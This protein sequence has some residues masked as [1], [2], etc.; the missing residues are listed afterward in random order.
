MQSRNRYILIHELF[1]IL[2]RKEVLYM[3]DLE[4]LAKIKSVF[5]TLQDIQIHGNYFQGIPILDELE[6]AYVRLFDRIN[7]DRNTCLS[8]SI[9]GKNYYVSSSLYGDFVDEYGNAY[10]CGDLDFYWYDNLDILLKNELMRD[11]VFG[12]FYALDKNNQ[13]I[14]RTV[15][16]DKEHTKILGIECDEESDNDFSNMK[17]KKIRLS[18]GIEFNVD[19]KM[20]IIKIYSRDRKREERM[21]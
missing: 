15:A 7:K 13:R 3:G 14:E 16:L 17:D 4:V 20:S 1:G 5:E 8:V 11:V 10:T 2:I 19:D 6:E 12:T 21:F 18:N 9:N